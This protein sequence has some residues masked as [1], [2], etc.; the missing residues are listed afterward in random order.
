[1]ATVVR[2]RIGS[3]TDCQIEE[4]G[5]KMAKGALMRPSAVEKSNGRLRSNMQ[6]RWR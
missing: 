1:M 4:D 3:P 6:P 5:E 2:E